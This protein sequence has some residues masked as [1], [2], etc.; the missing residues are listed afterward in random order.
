MS[1]ALALVCGIVIGLVLGA[2]G[3]GGSILAVPA[4][5]YVLGESARD[6]TTTSLVVIGI[7]SAIGAIS[8]H[9]ER[10]VRWRVGLTFGLVGIAASFAGTA[11][12]Q[13]VDQGVLLA[14]FAAVMAIAATAMI[15]KS[16][17]GRRS[18]LPRASREQPWSAP[19]GSTAG[20][21]TLT[22]PAPSVTRSGR[23]R[24]LVGIQVVSAALL[25]GFL[26]GFLGVGGGFVVVPAL[27]MIL[28][29]PMPVATATSLLIIALNSSV[30]LGIHASSHPQFDWAI[31]VPFT[32]ATIIASLVGKKV[33][34]RLSGGVLTFSFA[35]VLLLV[36]VGIGIEVAAPH[37][38]LT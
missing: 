35:I 14:C 38:G 30:S 19:R 2:L 26:T 29:F 36:A 13:N 11:L 10:Q 5:V 8:Y 7:S 21:A 34:S 4:L 12:N 1:I 3:G 31:I 23:G 24:A 32:A 28:G 37:I 33:A 25:V 27:V 16:W 20:A 17:T 18:K 9:R 22:A 6:A 15:G